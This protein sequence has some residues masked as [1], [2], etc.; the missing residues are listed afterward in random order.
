MLNNILQYMALIDNIYM[1]IIL[2]LSVVWHQSKQ[3]D[4]PTLTVSYL[5]ITNFTVL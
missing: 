5:N 4:R 1:I 2:N 3:V